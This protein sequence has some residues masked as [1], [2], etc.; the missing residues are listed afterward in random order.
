MSG[1]QGECERTRI[2]DT[3]SSTGDRTGV[4]TIGS[5]VVNTPVR[6]VRGRKSDHILSPYDTGA[7][8]VW[9]GEVRVGSPSYYGTWVGEGG[10][11]VGRIYDFL[12]KN[13]SLEFLILYSRSFG[14][15]ITGLLKTRN[16]DN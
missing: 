10:G 7:D 3:P 4:V 9:V 5:G 2:L 13:I 6:S 8:W 16:L 12:D 15:D 1:G 11:T 14:A